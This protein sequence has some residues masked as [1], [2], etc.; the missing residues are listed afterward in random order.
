MK[1]PIPHY[2]QEHAE[3]LS[4]MRNEPVYLFQA[5]AGDWRIRLMGRLLDREAKTLEYRFDGEWRKLTNQDR[6]DIRERLANPP[7]AVVAA[8]PKRGRK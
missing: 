8:K 4:A 5:N 3:C 2:T 6:N 7:E 1:L